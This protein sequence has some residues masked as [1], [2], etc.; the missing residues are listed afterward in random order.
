[1]VYPLHHHPAAEAYLVLSGDAE[2]RRG[3]GR[4]RWEPPGSVIYHAPGVPHATRAGA[5]PLLA[6]YLWRGDLATHARLLPAGRRFRA[7]P[8][9]PGRG[10]G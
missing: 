1:M 8:L 2:W 3:A 6:V 5:D 7:R 10:G 9:T 4:W